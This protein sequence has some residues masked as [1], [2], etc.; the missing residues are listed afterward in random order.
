MI[1]KVQH[2]PLAD[3]PACISH[4]VIVQKNLSWKVLVHGHEVD[5]Q[6]AGLSSI[7]E[8]IEAVHTIEQLLFKIDHLNVCAGN[9]D[10]HF[11][12]MVEQR[13]GVLK[14]TSGNVAAY[15]DKAAPVEL[16][17]QVYNATL[18]TM[19]CILLT[20]TSK[21]SCCVAY[22]D[23]ARSMYHRWTKS[24]RERQSHSTS[25][26]NEKWMK[27]PEKKQKMEDLKKRV[28]SAEKSIR[29]SV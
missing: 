29:Y 28:R 7:P 11:I 22:R 26:M 23:I 2:Q 12:E 8:K 5:P 19:K 25:H 17:G 14:S 16:N 1:L 13:K 21:C 27:T 10:Q 15:I 20:S 6:T 24:S 9:P 18:R 4:C 3:I